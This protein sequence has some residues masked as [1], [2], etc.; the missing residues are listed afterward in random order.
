VRSL[1]S[2]LTSASCI[3]E[4]RFVNRDS[5]PAGLV[6]GYVPRLAGFRSHHPSRITRQCTTPTF[7]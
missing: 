3:P 5:A 7:V 6:V 2:P 1:R 4:A